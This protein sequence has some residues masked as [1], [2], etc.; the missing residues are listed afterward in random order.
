MGRSVNRFAGASS[1][2]VNSEMVLAYWHIGREVVEY[3]QG[4]AF[5]ADYGTN[6]KASQAS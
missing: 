1:E 4:G 5:R 3:H 2:T 6:R